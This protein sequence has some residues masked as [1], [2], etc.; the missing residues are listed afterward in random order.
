AKRLVH[1][2]LDKIIQM[3][4][5]LSMR[6]RL[7]HKELNEMATR[8]GFKCKSKD[9]YYNFRE[10]LSKKRTSKRKI[11]S[12]RKIVPVKHKRLS[13]MDLCSKKHKKGK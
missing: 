8:W 5:Y 10:K 9:E 1:L 13:V 6:P 4:E 3:S 12:G 2:H 7:E 11:L